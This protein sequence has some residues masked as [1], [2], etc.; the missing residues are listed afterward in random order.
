MDQLQPQ[1]RVSSGVSIVHPDGTGLRPVSENGGW[2]VWWPDGEHLGFQVVGRDGNEQIKVVHLKTGEKRTLP[3]LH[4]TGTNFPFDISRDGKWLGTTNA[5]HISD[6][7]WL[8]EP[9]ESK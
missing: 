6:E 4:F 3:N 8:L 7:I 5:Q 2:A 1:P 9:A